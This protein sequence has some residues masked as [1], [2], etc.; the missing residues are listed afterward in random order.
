ML[1]MA[2]LTGS[3]LAIGYYSSC[4]LLFVFRLLDQ[5]RWGH[6]IG[7]VQMLAVLPLAWLILVALRLGRP[8]LYYVQICLMLAFLLAETLLHFV[9]KVDFRR[10]RWMVICYIVL[11]FSAMG[12]MLGVAA[13]GGRPLTVAAGTLFLAMAVMA[14]VQRAITGL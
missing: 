6:W 4:I 2:N 12:G 11:F 5:A 14:F 1:E 9:L 3:L 8:L 7:Y 13:L 10:T